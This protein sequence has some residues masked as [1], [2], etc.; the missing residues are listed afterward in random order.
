MSHGSDLSQLISRIVN[1]WPYRKGKEGVGD[2]VHPGPLGVVAFA[3][4]MTI[5][6]GYGP[7][8]Y[9]NYSWLLVFCVSL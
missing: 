2:G 9:W 5:R 7:I 6:E 8:R 1:W 3:K 4:V